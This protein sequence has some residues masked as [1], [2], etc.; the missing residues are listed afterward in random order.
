M[1]KTC[2]TCRHHEK[3]YSTNYC[4]RKGRE[5]PNPVTGVRE[6]IE[7]NCIQERKADT[8]GYRGEICGI[9]AKFWEEKLTWGASY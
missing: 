1:M 7:L 6:Q 9:D 4:Y 2:K 3:T 5:A 8:V